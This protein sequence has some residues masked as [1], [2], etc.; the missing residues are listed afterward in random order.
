MIDIAKTVRIPVRRS[1]PTSAPACTVIVFAKQSRACKSTSWLKN[2]DAEREQ[3]RHIVY[4]CAG[5]E[6]ARCPGQIPIR[7]AIA[8]D[9]RNNLNRQLHHRNGDLLDSGASGPHC[10]HYDVGLRPKDFQLAIAATMS[11]TDENEHTGSKLSLRA[12]SA[13]V[14]GGLPP[15]LPA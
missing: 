15:P 7:Q 10:P 1:P 6:I 4:D 13:A 11:N 5:G 12:S 8:Q 3:F 2:K 14:S 9:E